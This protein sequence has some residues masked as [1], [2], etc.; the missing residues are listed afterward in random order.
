MD[1]ETV[2][3]KESAYVMHTYGRVPVNFVKGEGCTLVDSEGKHYID[4]TSGIGVNALGH[5]HKGLVDAISNQASTL[6]HVSNLYYT[7]PMVEV[8][9]QLAKGSGLKKVFFANSGAEANEGLI[10]CARKYSYDKYGDNRYVILTLKQSFH[11]RTMNTLKATGQPKFHQWFY[12]FPEGFDYVVANDFEEFKQH[13]NT[14]VCAGLMELV[15][16][17]GGVLPLD[18]EY[19][20]KVSAYCKEHD[21]LV[22]VDEVQTGIGRTGSLFAYQQYG[23]EPDIVSMAKGL[24]GGFPIGGFLVGE[25]C[26]NTMQPGQ[27]GSTFGGTPLGCAAAKVVLETVDTPEFLESV[28]IKGNYFMDGIRN[29]HSENIKDVR[30]MGLMIGIIVDADQRASYVETLRDKGILVLTAGVDAIRLLPPLVITKEE[31]DT[32]LS[33]MK[34]VFE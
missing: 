16:G 23:I 10:K 29:L 24:G 20:Q 25:K 11:G 8:A 17:E 32:C 33:V 30:G 28:K 22:C 5:N 34:E 15:Q 27:H 26:E 19:V 2:K 18:K 6:M 3:Q 7:E 13:V 4:L 14:H 9:E 21:I 12:P 1:F 31:I